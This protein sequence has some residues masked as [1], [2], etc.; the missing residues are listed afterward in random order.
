VQVADVVGTF[1]ARLRSCRTAA[2]LSQEDLAVR[3]GLSVRA[4]SNLERDRVGRPRESTVALLAE[5]LRLSDPERLRLLA[6]RSRGRHLGTSVYDP[7]RHPA[8]QPRQL[9]RQAQHFVG[10]EREVQSLDAALARSTAA[11]AM[12]VATSEVIA[13]TGPAGVGKTALAVRWA[14]R[15][16]DRFPDGHFYVDLRGFASGPQVAP[17]DALAHI[18]LALGVDAT[19]LPEQPDQLACLFRTVSA[20]QRMLILLDNVADADQV[21]P[22]LPANS[23]SL[24]VVTSRDRLAGLV[25]VDGAH[26]LSLDVLD[27]QTA[28][29]LIACLVG[30]E[31]VAADPEGA[32]RLAQRCG[33][34]PLALRVAAAHIAHAPHLTLREHA[35]RLN[36][37]QGGEDSLATVRSAL[38]AT[39]GRLPPQTRRLFRLLGLAPDAEV[40]VAVAAALAD[41]TFAQATVHLERL[42]AVHLIEGTGPGRYRLTELLRHYAV[43]RCGEDETRRARRRATHR[44]AD[45]LDGRV[46]A[47]SEFPHPSIWRLSTARY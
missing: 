26:A 44:L 41:E 29:E 33:L 12:G 17:S 2:G 23:G 35:D 39:Y 8:A 45:W 38:D 21:R 31:R 25:A 14:H 9:P 4:I 36:L 3:S 1:G 37:L 11:P 19:R 28:R 24:V 15:V 47:P 43:E 46:P 27:P 22:L 5:A 10:R 18:L 32:A 13:I 34:L 30:S 6:A 16:A 42:R 40:T 20:R 7:P